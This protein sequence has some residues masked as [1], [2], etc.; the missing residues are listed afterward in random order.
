MVWV[1]NLLVNVALEAFGRLEDDG[2]GGGDFD[3]FAIGRVGADAGFA[4]LDDEVAETGNL[5]FSALAEF[6]FNEGE[7]GFDDGFDFAS[8]NR[9]FVGDGFDEF[10]FVHDFL[11]PMLNR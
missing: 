3:L 7:A 10:S 6:F 4:F 8:G 5:D 9:D 2:L 1:I 11:P